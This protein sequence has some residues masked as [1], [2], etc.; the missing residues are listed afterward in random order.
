[1]TTRVWDRFITERDQLVLKASG[2]GKLAGF[3]TR[4]ALVIVD[5]SYNFVGVEP[6]PI[7]QSIKRWRNSCGQEAWDALPVIR[8]LIDVCRG[9]CPIIYTTNTRRSDGFDAGSWRW[10]NARELEDNQKEID[11][12]EIVA[13]IRPR[14]ED[15]VIYKTK[16]S[17]FFGTPLLSFLIDLNVDSLIVAGVSTSGCVRATVIDA[18]SYNFRCCVVEDA[19]FDRTEASHAINLFDM[20]A[21]YADVRPS[22]EVLPYLQA[23]K[24][25]ASP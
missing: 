7:L 20:N 14:P 9:R 25:G 4:P 19:C 21:K 11:G 10:K 8:S 23:L 13:E 15:I 6:E 5:V 2:Y 17:G 18:F 3:G 1:M 24:S 16:P 12:N 22:R